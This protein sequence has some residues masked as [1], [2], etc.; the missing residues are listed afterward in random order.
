MPASSDQR[1]QTSTERSWR[2]DGG[3]WIILVVAALLSFTRFR[4]PLQE[5]QEARYAEIPR[6]MLT[7][8]HF[9]VPVLHGQPYLDKPPLLYWLVMSSYAVFGV[10]DWAARLVS[11]TAMFLC[12]VVTYSWGR[13]LAGFRAAFAGTLIL[14][15]SPRFI[16]LDRMLM[17]D[18]LLCLCVVTA[19]AT[20]HIALVE[21]RSWSTWWVASAVACGFGILTKGPVSL[22]LVVIPITAY[23][24]LDLSPGRFRWHW[25]MIYSAIAI[26][27]AGPWYLAVTIH[28][29]D[30]LG[31]FFWFHN[32]QRFVEPF[33]HAEPVWFYLP[34]LFLGMLPWTLMLP[35]LIVRFLC[36][37]I[38]GTK[39][40]LP[41]HPVLRG[42]GVGG[43]GAEATDK[44]LGFGQQPGSP[45]PNP[46]PPTTG[47]GEGASCHL[48][49]QVAPRYFV[50]CSLWC[51]V[52][53]SLAG[54]KRASYILPAM[55]PLALALGFYL[56]T[57]VSIRSFLYDSWT[58]VLRHPWIVVAATC[59]L[60]ALGG[61]YQFLPRYARSYSLRGQV[62]R[63]FD[64]QVPVVCYPRRWDS[65]SFYLQRNDVHAYTVEQLS[66]LL[67]DLRQMP[68]A[69]V[70]LKNGHAE[71]SPSANLLRQLPSSMVFERMGRQGALTVGRVKQLPPG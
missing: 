42:R 50:A 21:A 10:H 2:C 37:Q 44:S 47:R 40:F 16:Q 46:L 5:P 35:V 22:A 34:V 20:A 53:F 60:I 17:M 61:V 26:G 48:L 65:V 70:F 51:L 52:F 18:G 64:T 55:P 7:E 56:C 29:P 19:W 41:S 66:D 69:L 27:V 3:L 43:E 63:H 58:S 23:R 24:W 8:G 54:C 6:Q 71:S 28:D 13:R 49:S 32:L 33:D 9:I 31:Y 25:L 14:C 62:R 57:L 15:L 36:R 11:C 1:I 12:V 4:C 59:F 39:T 38:A 68:E 67:A 30:F 45:H